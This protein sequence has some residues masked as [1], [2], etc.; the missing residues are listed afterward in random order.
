MVLLRTQLV[1]PG[2]YCVKFQ[3]KDQFQGMFDHQGYLT[4][5]ETALFVSLARRRKYSA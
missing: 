1:Y 3:A 2:R 4:R 5:N